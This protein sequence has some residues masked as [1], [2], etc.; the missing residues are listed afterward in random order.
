MDR[1]NVQRTGRSALDNSVT[2]KGTV[3]LKSLLL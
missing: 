1:E 3:A 2:K